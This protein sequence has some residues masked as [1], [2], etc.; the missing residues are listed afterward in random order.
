MQEDLKSPKFQLATP[1]KFS[2]GEEVSEMAASTS[3]EEALWL[4]V[5]SV[6]QESDWQQCLNTW[7][8]EI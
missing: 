6:E 4:F 5:Q 1:E 7:E 2:L 3:M 8:A